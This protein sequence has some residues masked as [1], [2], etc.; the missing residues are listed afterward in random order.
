MSGYEP[1]LE[2][3]KKKIELLDEIKVSEVGLI[4]KLWYLTRRDPKDFLRAEVQN[5]EL[6]LE[7]GP[8][9]LAYAA[10]S[11]QKLL[12]QEFF[13]LSAIKDN[14]KYLLLQIYLKHMEKS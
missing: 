2:A 6:R 4:S 7:S 13:D 10:S 9:Y 8:E 3:L 5:I 12:K 14:L 1:A 11:L